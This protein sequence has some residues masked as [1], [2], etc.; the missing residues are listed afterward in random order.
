MAVHCYSDR[1]DWKAVS[2]YKF[3][4]DENLK[5]P[6]PHDTTWYNMSS[7]FGRGLF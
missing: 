6:W 5:K 3:L 7:S 2:F 1:R 4:R